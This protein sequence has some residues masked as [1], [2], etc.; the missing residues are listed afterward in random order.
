MAACDLATFG[1]GK[2][3]VYAESHRKPV[4][5]DAS[6]FSVQFDLAR[7]GLIRT[8]EENLRIETV[9]YKLNVYGNLAFVAGSPPQGSQMGIR[10]HMPYRL[11]IFS[12]PRIRR[13][14]Q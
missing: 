7:S 6:N 12:F 5:M 13:V 2:G 4:K 11:A 1:R 14:L 9:L 8:I 10:R 3:D